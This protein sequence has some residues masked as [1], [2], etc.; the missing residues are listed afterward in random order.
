MYF[1]ITNDF[2]TFSKAIRIFFFAVTIMKSL[3]FMI[4]IYRTNWYLIFILFT[5]KSFALYMHNGVLTRTTPI[6]KKT[7]ID[8]MIL[9]SPDLYQRRNLNI[10]HLILCYVFWNVKIWYYLWKYVNKVLCDSSDFSWSRI[11]TSWCVC[12]WIFFF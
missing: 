1:F 3:G 9:I 11:W 4:L 12:L 8:F 5:I 6:I 10:W 2:S 7:S